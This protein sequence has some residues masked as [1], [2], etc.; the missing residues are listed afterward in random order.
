ME[1]RG[2]LGWYQPMDTK[3]WVPAHLAVGPRVSRDCVAG[4]GPRVADYRGCRVPTLLPTRW[5]VG[6]YP[7]LI[8]Y[9]E[10]LVPVS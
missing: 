7:V 4:P 10:D 5:W 2:F 6:T 9:R 1:Y 8:K 3:G